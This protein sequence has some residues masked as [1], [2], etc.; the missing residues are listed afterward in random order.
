MKTKKKFEVI[1]ESRFL[2][3]DE[4]GRIA[5]GDSNCSSGLAVY[6]MCSG[7]TELSIKPCLWQITCSD[8]EGLHTCGNGSPYDWEVGCFS[9]D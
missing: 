4:L 6:A 2:N 7:D 5:G 1:E 3:C 8:A 9:Y